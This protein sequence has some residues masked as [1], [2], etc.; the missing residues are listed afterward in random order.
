MAMSSGN[1]SLLDNGQEVTITE[2][3]AD[4]VIVAGAN[5]RP[6]L[7]TTPV[8]VVKYLIRGYTGDGLPFELWLEPHEFVE[9]T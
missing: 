3:G 7:G 8:D 4:G 6:K 5:M 2:T 1:V 9:K